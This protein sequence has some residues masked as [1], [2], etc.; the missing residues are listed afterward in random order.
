MTRAPLKIAL[1]GGTFDPP[2][3]GHLFIAQE[4]VRQ[5]GIS[6]VI[7]LPCRQSPHKQARPGASDAARLDMLQLATFGLPWAEVSRYELD[8]PSV[9]YSWETAQHFSRRH[10]DADLH[11]LLGADQWEALPR[12]AHPEIL[13]KLL[14]FIVFARNGVAPRPRPPFRAQFLVGENPVSATEIRERLR[15]HESGDELLSAS[16][17]DYLRQHPIY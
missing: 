13:A 12:W 3:R 10:P 4:A 11:W 8:K 9:S 1:F 14:T 17:A 15:R 2:H 16:V 7:F 5:C 6:R